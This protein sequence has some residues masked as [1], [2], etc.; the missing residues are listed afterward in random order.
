M[1]LFRQCGELIRGPLAV[2]TEDETPRAVADD[3][4][5]A[6]VFAPAH[7]G[8]GLDPC[9]D[10]HALDCCASAVVA[11]QGNGQRVAPG[12]G[13]MAEIMAAQ[14]AVNS[15]VLAARRVVGKAQRRAPLINNPID[16]RQ[17]EMPAAGVIQHVVAA[18]CFHAV[19][20]DRRGNSKEVLRLVEPQRRA[21]AVFRPNA[22]FGE[23]S[24][25][26]IIQAAMSPGR[27]R[28]TEGTTRSP[29]CQSLTSRPTAST[30]AAHS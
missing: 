9:G 14:P 26:Q 25:W 10:R 16:V 17:I 3:V 18:A 30:C 1:A 29:T 5:L 8:G 24:Q 2:Q 4:P 11:R 20:G 7:F 28:R 15:I 19:I 6:A 23:L 12:L 21:K 22:S 13:Q 27:L